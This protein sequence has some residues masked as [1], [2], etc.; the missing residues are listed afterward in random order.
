ML[1]MRHLFLGVFFIFLLGGAIAL[2][3]FARQGSTTHFPLEDRNPVTHLRWN[4][5]SEDFQFAVVS[6]R[7]GGHR[8]N[9]FS[10]A[11]LKLNLLQPAF[12]I[13]VGDLIEGGKKTPD[14]LKKEWDEFDGFVT[15]LSMPFF[16]VAGN[17]DVA[18]KEATKFWEEKLGR[19]HYQFVYRNVLF[20]ALNSDDPPGTNGA[21]GP[22]QVA[23][24]KQTLANHRDVP[25]TI[26]IVHRP[27]WT[28]K[29]GEQNGWKDIE[30]ALVGRR[31][32]VFAGHIH[33]FQ[34]FIRNGQFYYQL[35]TTGGSSTLRGVEQGEF[36]HITWVTMK[37]DGPLL[38]HIALDAI[39][40][41]DLQPF[42]T[43]E[44]V[45]GKAKAP[46]YSVRG[47]AYFEGTPMP[48]AVVTL[49]PSGKGGK[50]LK[51]TGIVQADG[52]FELT[53][54]QGKDGA[55]EGE[56]TVTVTWREKLRNGQPGAG[57]LPDRYGKADQS[58]LR[59]RVEPGVNELVFELRK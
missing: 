6:D 18:A 7:T 48:G 1:T 57:L 33:R 34:K 28:A 37:K 47:Q 29:N 10:Q 26:V 58:G 45:V 2:S 35:A 17:H 50:G 55:A 43:N 30:D 27:L 53:T 32:T 3:N 13:T 14:K 8:A 9:V 36:D 59:A 25:W 31:Y 42:V 40:K 11:A 22:E 23:W 46:V 12:V 19:K 4:D 49:T 21:I 20:L 51:A 38:A 52:S 16:Y 54:Y 5:S 41:E 15:K 24:A 44:P 56:Y 39:H